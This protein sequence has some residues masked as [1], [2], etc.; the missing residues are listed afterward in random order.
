MGS[1]THVDTVIDSKL[2]VATML[3]R[4]LF[5]HILSF[6]QTALQ[7]LVKG[8]A[9]GE[10]VV[11]SFDGGSSWLIME[12]GRGWFAVNHFEGGNSC[13]GVHGCAI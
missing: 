5:H 7:G 6:S 8:R 3:I 2:D 13:T 12:K 11:R 10:E 9:S 4:C 1:Q